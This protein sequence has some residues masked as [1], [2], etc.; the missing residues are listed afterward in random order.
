M[1]A[2]QEQ[3]LS[4][5]ESAA[6]GTNEVEQEANQMEACSMEPRQQVV[7]LMF[8]TPDW[9]LLKRNLTLYLGIWLQ[10]TPLVQYRDDPVAEITPFLLHDPTRVIPEFERIFTK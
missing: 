6:Q 8:T 1:R 7:T 10:D 4:V 5:S 2:E 9:K 3:G